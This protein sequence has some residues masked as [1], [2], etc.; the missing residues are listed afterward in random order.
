MVPMREL[1][2]FTVH[3]LMLESVRGADGRL[4]VDLVVV[5]WLYFLRAG[6]AV[7]IGVARDPIRRAQTLQTGHVDPVTFLGGISYQAQREV[8]E[9][10]RAEHRRWSELRLRGEWFRAD[11]MLLARAA[12]ALATF[13]YPQRPVDDPYGVAVEN[14]D[15]QA[16]IETLRRIMHRRRLTSKRT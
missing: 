4:P 14:G 10:E 6:D 5:N 11:L 16:D 13:G 12:E 3:E 2:T 9:A 8:F 1:Q 7:K 15:A